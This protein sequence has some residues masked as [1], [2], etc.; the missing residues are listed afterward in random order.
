VLVDEAGHGVVVFDPWW[1]QGSDCGVVVVGGE[2]VVA[3]VGPVVVEMVCVVAED[4]RGVTTA[5]EQDPVGALLAYGPYEAFRVRVAVGTARGDLHHGDGFA[6]ENRVE[7]G[8]ELG[9]TVSGQESESAGVVA[10]LSQQLPGLLG[11]PGG[12][13]VGGHPEDVHLSGAHLHG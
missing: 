6:G 3:L 11:D 5:E 8:G 1:G 4:L 13:G 9:V 12:G 2:L 7:R 10:D